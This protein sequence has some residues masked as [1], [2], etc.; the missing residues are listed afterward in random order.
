[1]KYPDVGWNCRVYFVFAAMLPIFLFLRISVVCQDS[2]TDEQLRKTRIDRTVDPEFLRWKIILDALVQDARTAFPEERRPYAIADVA[3]TYWYV[4]KDD[5]GKQFDLALDKAI[6]LYRIDKKYKP[7]VD[8]VIAVAARRAPARIK[9]LAKRL[10][11]ADKESKTGLS[12]E[13]ALDLVDENPELAAQI[14]ESFAPKG[15]HDGTAILLIFRLA[16]RN[17]QLSDRVFN[18]YLN[19]V[20]ANESI[21]LEAVVTLAGYA[22]GNPEYYSVGTSGQYFGMSMKPIPGLRANSAMANAFLNIAYSR[23]NTAI[24]ARNNAAGEDMA[25]RNFPILFALGYLLPEVGRISPTAMPAWQQLMAQGNVGVSA[26]QAQIVQ[27][28]LTRIHQNRERVRTF[29]DGSQI[30]ELEAEASL[31]NVEKLTG[32]CERDVVYSKAALLFDSRKNFKRAFELVE[33]IEDINQNAAVKQALYI[34]RADVEMKNGDW[35]AV[36]ENAEKVSSLEQR[37]II[38]VE[39]ASEEGPERDEFLR[40]SVRLTEKFAN[41]K[42]RAGVLFS[43]STLTLKSD[44][45]EALKQL[46]NAVSNLNKDEPKDEMS[47]SVPIRVP[48]SCGDKGKWW[49]GFSSLPHSTV[50]EATNVFAKRFPDHALR[51]ADEISDKIIRI[52]ASAR[53]AGIALETWEKNRK[54][55]TL[56]ERTFN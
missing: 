29:N 32:T 37:A 2:P 51:T 44:W 40:E 9:S 38:Y 1:M 46:S 50:F 23:I 36:R 34:S 47:F 21:P 42:D 11:D 39:A 20:R 12:G 33:K 22:F 10:A 26:P 30:P 6:S 3:S 54:R 27:G 19:A 15:L 31:E 4:D 5:S 43:V 25:A 48:L 52:R 18:T 13:T 17:P 24:E 56:S 28:I 45:Q 35:K 16:E 49:G 7:S 14:A 8:Y 55:S 41:A 53:I